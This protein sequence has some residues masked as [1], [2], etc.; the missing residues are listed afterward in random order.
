M[1]DGYVDIYLL[2]IPRDNLEEYTRQAAL[3]GQVVTEHGALSYRA[4]RADDP[5]DGF[6]VEEGQLLTAAVADFESREHR[7]EV[8]ATVMEDP[9]VKGLMEGEQRADM[10]LMRYGGFETFVSA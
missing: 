4:F 6:T 10:S 7:D 2:P 8:M 3:F 5:G 1:A 9:R